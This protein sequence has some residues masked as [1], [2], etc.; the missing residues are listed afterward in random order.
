MKHITKTEVLSNGG[1][2]MYLPLFKKY[3][4]MRKHLKGAQRLKTDFS[5]TA[6][7]V[8]KPLK[9]YMKKVVKYDVQ[10]VNN[11]IT[12]F[13]KETQTLFFGAKVWTSRVSV[14]TESDIETLEL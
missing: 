5:I 6:Q 13:S 1:Y 7:F 4:E 11:A 14:P 10:L 8:F 12:T 3:L 2:R 9:K